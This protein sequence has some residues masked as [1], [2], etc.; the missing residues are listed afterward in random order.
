M[1]NLAAVLF[2]LTP[3]EAIAAVTAGAARAL[4]RIAQTG[5][6]TVGKEATV[7]VWEVQEPAALVTDLSSDPLH[8]VF[9]RG[10]ERH[11]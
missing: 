4:G 7:C 2:S 5:T 11:A 1:L 3:A 6:I 8:R 9:I 10:E